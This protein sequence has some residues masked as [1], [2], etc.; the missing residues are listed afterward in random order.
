MLGRRFEGL[1][2]FVGMEQQRNDAIRAHH[3]QLKEKL[4]AVGAELLQ[5]RKNAASLT[6]VYTQARKEIEAQFGEQVQRLG[7]RIA[8]QQRELQARGEEMAAQGREFQVQLAKKDDEIKKLKARIEEI[9]LEFAVI[10]KE[11]LEKM[12]GQFELAD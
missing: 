5:E 1:Q 8:E 2:A 3:E 9:S 6:E 12:Q 11:T 4:T 7:A 10:L